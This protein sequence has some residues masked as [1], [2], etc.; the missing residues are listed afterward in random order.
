MLYIYM[1]I[2]YHELLVLGDALIVW[3]KLHTAYRDLQVTI[4][5][6]Y[7]KLPSDLFIIKSHL[8]VFISMFD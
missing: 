5:G 4:F 6:F 2:Y 1:Y 3:C 7:M 8:K